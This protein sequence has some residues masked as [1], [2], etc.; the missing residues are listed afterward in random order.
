LETL[1]ARLA[2]HHLRPD[3]VTAEPLAVPLTE[4]GWTVLARADAAV[5][6]TGPGEGIKFPLMALETIVPQL[7]AQRPETARVTLLGDAAAVPLAVFDGLEVITAAVPDAT[8]LIAGLR[9]QSPPA[10]LE[11]SASAALRRRARQLWLAAAAA[12]LVAMLTY[13][14]LLTL[15]NAREAERAS[16]LA[17]ANEATVRAAFPEISRVVNPRVQATQA[18][19]DLRGRAL[20]V[21]P[22]L[23]QLAAFERAFATGFAEHGRVRSIAY[24]NGVL[25]ISIATPDMAGLERIRTVLGDAGLG[26]EM[27]SAE[28]NDDGV[29]A[30]LR[31]Q[32]PG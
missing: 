27:L 17:A 15:G 11:A 8:T 3:L 32:E 26:A 20:T 12:T 25:E 5:I 2:E 24:T 9:Q 6:R 1:S 23:D 22:F 28:S 18:L 30:R 13:P 31:L 4:Q 7:R 10:L 19:T 16:A 29:I 14:A 21:A